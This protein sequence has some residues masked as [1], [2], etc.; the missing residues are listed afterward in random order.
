MVRKTTTGVTR[1]SRYLSFVCVLSFL[2]LFNPRVKLW[3]SANG[4]QS[5]A[6]EAYRAENGFFVFNFVL[7]LDG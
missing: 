2:Q 4:G 5:D 1:S 7:L 6:S 3:L